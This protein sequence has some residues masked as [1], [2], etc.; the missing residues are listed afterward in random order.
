VRRPSI[1]SRGWLPDKQVLH[2]HVVCYDAI[3]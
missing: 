1:L 3:T 2:G